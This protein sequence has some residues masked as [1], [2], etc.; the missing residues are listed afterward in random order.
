MHSGL[1]GCHFEG[2]S[3]FPMDDSDQCILTFFV[4]RSHP[5]DMT[6]EMPFREEF[7][8]D[9]LFD[10]GRVPIAEAAGRNECIDETLGH[11]YVP[12]A[13]RREKDFA[14]GT[15]VD[16]AARGVETLQRGEGTSAIAKLAVLPTF[17][18]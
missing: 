8:D 1:V 7:R 11:H 14:K 10:G 16:D 6:G 5:A 15:G 18:A 9:G 2:A 13:E 3:E 4:K 12:Q 17:D